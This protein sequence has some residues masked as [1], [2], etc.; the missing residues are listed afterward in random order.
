MNRPTPH[1]R[2]SQHPS[3]D[4][5]PTDEDHLAKLPRIFS[6][7]IKLLHLEKMNYEEIARD[8]NWPIGTVKSRIFRGREMIRRARRLAEPMQGAQA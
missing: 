8:K 4:L 6:D 1:E 7:P 2:A 3:F 5:L